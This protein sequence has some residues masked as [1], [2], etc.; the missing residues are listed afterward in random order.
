M[1]VM[2][3]RTGGPPR[4]S[5]G[6]GVLAGLR[7]RLRRRGTVP[8]ADPDLGPVVRPGPAGGSVGRVG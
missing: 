2:E 7:G 5:R 6:P 3:F 8:V 4:R 1:T